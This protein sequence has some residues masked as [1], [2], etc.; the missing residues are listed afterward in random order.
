[1]FATV[2]TV[3]LVSHLTAQT[4]AVSLADYQR[5]VGL[6][7]RFTGKATGV[8]GGAV[9]L[10]SGKFWYRKSVPGG[11]TFVLVDPAS[12]TKAAAFDEAR[13][14]SAL[15]QAT[16]ATYTALTL[17]FS[18]FTMDDEGRAIRF[19]AG[20]AGW[21]CTVGEYVCTKGPAPEGGGRGRGGPPSGNRAAG[22]GV[23]SP[24]KKSIAFIRN[25]N[26]HV[27]AAMRRRWWRGRDDAR[28]WRITR[29][30]IKAS[31][32]RPT[33][34]KSPPRAS[35]SAAT[36]GWCATSIRRRP[37]GCSRRPSSGSMR[38]RATRST[39]RSAVLIDVA[40]SRETPVD[41]AALP[42][43]HTTCH[44]L[45]WWR[46]SRA[47]TFEY[48]ER[49]HQVYRVIEVDAATA[50]AR[51]LIEEKSDT[52]IHYARATGDLATGGRTFRHDVTTDARSSGC[53]S[54]TAGR[55]CI[56]MTAPPAG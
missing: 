32:G 20:E 30:P 11:H 42:E 43:L 44:A 55:I 48:N 37:I 47:F 49:G 46:D 17:P 7:A 36:G 40:A 52:F 12:G 2:A 24:D 25:N 54:E 45:E 35:S 18:T 27:R 28:H 50:A 33:R 23:P 38:S 41:R 39:A 3:A 34:R 13:L 10:A 53:R 31:S 21:S 26:I 29:T 8:T 6:Q 14:A 16:G 22:G 9:W 1:M 4:P 5:A 51:T 15:G 56:S 19:S